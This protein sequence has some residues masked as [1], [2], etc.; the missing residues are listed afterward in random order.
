MT[1]GYLGLRRPAAIRIPLAVVISLVFPL[2]EF[3]VLLRS[4]TERH[5]MRILW[6]RVARRR[7]PSAAFESET[8]A[9][10]VTPTP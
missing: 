5:R 1:V 3:A 2:A 6:E 7:Q 9:S 10:V 8:E 4:S